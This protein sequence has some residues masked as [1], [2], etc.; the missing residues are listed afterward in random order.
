MKNTKIGNLYQIGINMSELTMCN[1][2]TFKSVER[3]VREGNTLVQRNIGDGIELCIVPNEIDFEK[4]S[5]VEKSKYDIGI[6]FMEL[7]DHCVC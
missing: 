1:Y 5:E 4:L 6:W 7:T 2:C 3:R